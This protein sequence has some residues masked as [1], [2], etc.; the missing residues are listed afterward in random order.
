MFLQLAKGFGIF[1]P[2]ME[3]LRILVLGSGGREHVYIWKLSQSSHNPDLFIAP[4]NAGTHHL[5]TNVNLSPVDFEAI[6]DFCLKQK[7]DILI[8]GS[9]DPLVK[10]IVDYM[11]ER[12]DLNHLFVFG[13]EAKVAE[14]EGSKDFAKEF[15]IENQIPTAGYR[16]F[17]P[18]EYAK[19]LE[20]IEIMPGPYVLKADGLAAG[21]GVVIVDSRHEAREVVKEMLIDR[22][23]GAACDKLVIEEFITG[24][25]FSVFAISDGVSY[26]I[27][28]M[29]KDYK[30]IGEGD[31]GLNTGG[32]GAVSP[33]P[34]VDTE[35]E[36]K[37]LDHIVHPTFEGFANRGVPFVGF[38]FFGLI[39]TPKSPM[40]IEYNVR[41]GDPETEV[42]FPRIKNDFVELIMAIKNR[43]LADVEIEVESGYC[44]TV[45]SVSGG[46]PEAYKTGVEIAIGEPLEGQFFHAGTSVVDQKVVTSG[47]RVLASTAK[48]KTLGE[49]L[50]RSYG[51][52]EKVQFDGIYYRKDIGKDLMEFENGNMA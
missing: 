14:L 22:K 45:F 16:T 40:V 10:G 34:F 35:V 13:P 15:M 33:V 32:M 46:Y 44:T 6:A 39:N 37:M 38:L 8:P 4:G 49:A 18:G 9:E 52:L 12:D 28:P 5:A 50:S 23:F 30:R 41:M 36:Q 21:K 17:G 3:K 31:T 20:H 48:G 47:G 26:K 29:A 7:I 1:L 2:L 24:I 43:R 19:A 27:L 25:E 42:V 11:R 51:N